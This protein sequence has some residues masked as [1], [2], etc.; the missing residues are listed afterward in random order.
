MGGRGLLSTDS[1]RKHCE[2]KWCQ[3]Y[4]TWC[5][6]IPVCSL[7][8]DRRSLFHGGVVVYDPSPCIAC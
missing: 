5:I 2:E 1:Y 8:L 6:Q 7:P 3:V 4:I